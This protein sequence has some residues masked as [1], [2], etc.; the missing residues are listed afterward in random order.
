MGASESACLRTHV[1]SCFESGANLAFVGA[2]HRWEPRSPLAQAAREVRMEPRQ[3]AH[4]ARVRYWLWT[5]KL[6]RERRR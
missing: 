4:Q 6:S 3:Q 2:V 1:T 5:R